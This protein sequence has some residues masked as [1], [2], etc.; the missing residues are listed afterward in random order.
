ME[1]RIRNRYNNKIQQE[2]AG[3]YGISVANMEELGGFE[4]FIYGFQREGQEYV[5]RIGHSLRRSPEMIRGEVDWLNYLAAGGVSVARAVPSANGL[6]V[7]EVAD[8]EGGSFLA[9]AFVKAPGTSAWRAGQWAAP[10]FVQY[11]QLIGRMHTLS[12]D[13]VPDPAGTRPHWD[14]DI[15]LGNLRQWLPEKDAFVA[16]KYEALVAHLRSLPRTRENYGMIHQDAHAGNFFVGENGRITLFDFDDCVYG[17]YIYDIAMVLFY[18]VTNEP[19]P[20]ALGRHFLSHFL[21]GYRQE[22]HLPAEWLQHIPAFMKLRELDLYA[23]IF[24]SFDDV[25]NIA[26]TWTANFMRGRRER[27]LHDVPY[28]D[29]D[30]SMFA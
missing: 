6:L 24:R 2:V 5:L 4:S 15:N 21:E 14:A 9:T 27:I 10:L 26:H 13:Y 3:R 18:A 25:E 1:A 19:E 8:G 30:F 28:L 12:R 7:E 20:E 16:D 29:L 23:I 17:H 22:S 11:G